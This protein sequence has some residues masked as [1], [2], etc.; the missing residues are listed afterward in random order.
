MYR[1]DF[2]RHANRVAYRQLLRHHLSSPAG[3]KQHLT[4]MAI[5]PFN[6]VADPLF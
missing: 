4:R 1:R 2:P 6:S 5:Y 3:S